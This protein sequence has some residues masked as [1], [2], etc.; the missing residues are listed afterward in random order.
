MASFGIKNLNRCDFFLLIWVIYYLQGIA[1]P[2]GGIISLALLGVNLLISA[3]CTLKVMQRR[4]GPIYFRGLNMLMFL[5]TIYGFILVLMGP[6]TL[7]YPI[8]GKSMP[9]YN[10]IKSIYLSM[11]PI[12][13]FY[14]YTKR[15]YLTAEHLR[16]WGVIFL[17]SVTLSYISMHRAALEALLEK[18]SHADEITNNSGYL[19]LSCLPLLVLYRK[20]PLIQFT[21]LA[22]VMAFIV[23]G[24]KRGAI[25]IG[26]VCA[27]YFMWQAIRNSTGKTRFMFII[28][29]VG[30][31]AGAVLFFIHQ[32]ST[33]NYMMKRIEDT[34]SG[35]S[36]GRDN[37]YT[38]FWNY[39]TENAD[40]THYLLGRGANGTLEIYYNYAHNDWLE[41]AV[42]QGLL[43]IIIYAFYWFCFYK[44]WK[45]A[46]NIDSKTILVLTALI[47]FAKTLFSMSYADMSYVSTSVLGYALATVNKT[48]T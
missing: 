19:F 22:F 44:T 1:Y 41:I 13:T 30:I 35:N 37:L 40:F 16:M 32:M 34:L 7:Y 33:S 26:L 6:S 3:S 29:S 25:V 23:M 21:A 17:A 20:K 42:N 39:F 45:H 28:L 9:S 14:Y 38:F 36:S 2:E 18:G 43:G 46:K 11:L 24:M 15:R 12:Y 8:S 48:N 31:C 5:F 10:Y 47:F 4:N 27:A